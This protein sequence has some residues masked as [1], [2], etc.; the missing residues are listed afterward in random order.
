MRSSQNYLLVS[1]RPRICSNVSA[2]SFD[3]KKS[4][5]LG[6]LTAVPF[7]DSFV[8][9]AH[10]KQSKNNKANRQKIITH[11]RIGIRSSFLFYS[12][13]VIM[14]KIYKWINRSEKIYP[15]F[16]VVAFSA[17]EVLLICPHEMEALQN[18]H[19]IKD[20][21]LTHPSFF[22]IFCLKKMI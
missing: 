9:H 15:N 13:F 17:D 3:E 6:H 21:Q 12:F 22:F 14:L 19:L 8:I 4:P 2:P 20:L 11:W 7:D 16:V 1:G 5:H 10:P 18:S